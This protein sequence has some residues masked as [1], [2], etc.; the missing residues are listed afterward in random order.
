MPS[1]KTLSF[2]SRIFCAVM[3]VGAAW[4]QSAVVRDEVPSL[5]V[6]AV[7]APHVPSWIRYSGTIQMQP[8][9]SEIAL[10]FAIYKDRT[11]T[12]ALWQETQNVHPDAAGNYSVLLGSTDPNG[13]PQPVFNSTD[14]QW[15]GVRVTGQPESSRGLLVSVPYALKTLD[16]ETLQGVPASQFVQRSEIPALVQKLAAQQQIAVVPQVQPVLGGATPATAG[17]VSTPI[18]ASTPTEV[19]LVQQ[20]GAGYAL[21]AVATSNSAVLAVT[22]STTSSNPTIYSANFSPIGVGTRSEVLPSKGTG[23]G[24]WGA[25]F[26]DGGTGVLGDEASA[27]GSTYGVRGKNAS[28]AGTGVYGINLAATGATTGVRGETRSAT[29]TAGVFDALN[30]GKILSGRNTGLEK[31]SVDGLGN[32]ASAGAVSAG[33]FAG[34][35]SQLAN[36]NAGFLGGLPP[37]A[38]VT[39]NSLGSLSSLNASQFQINADPATASQFGYAGF[40]RDDQDSVHSVINQAGSQ[41]HFRLSRSSPDPGGA[42]DLLIV[43]Y[44]FGMAV[45]YPGVLEFWTG[46]FSVH[47]NNSLGGHAGA[48]FWVGD[49]PDS[50]GLFVTANAA[51]FA[52]P[53]NVIIA[54]DKFNHTSHGSL[55]FV[56]RNLTDGFRFNSGPN[57]Q[58]SMFGQLFKTLSTSNIE[59][60]NGALTA[61][62]LANSDQ[63]AVQVGSRSASRVDIITADSTPQISVFPSGNVSIG[64]TSDTAKLAVGSSAQFQVSA[65]GAVTIG[66]GT[67]IVQHISTT[68]GVS[69]TSLAAASCQVSSVIA[70][71]AAD[72][73]SVALGVPNSL[74]SSGDLVLFGWVSAPGTVS[75]RACNMG[76]AS[77]TN[78]AGSVRVDVWKH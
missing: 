2:V 21:H 10:T 72:G 14:A 23:I 6:S 60:Y 18:E 71:G 59:A 38:F 54:A 22:T 75:I 25:S 9:Q 13:L 35:G 52:D 47:E 8:G 65:A 69:L 77:V 74:A 73:D 28:V 36:V 68:A 41:V 7:D 57:G 64:N 51:S 34:D 40:V 62:L 33:S 12:N 55:N 49:Q 78:A 29:G 1:C 76:A 43:P 3:F 11:T 27:T 70:T 48:M 42:K 63:N 16:A 17:T 66:G 56:I 37:S 46:H 26:G 30:G 58:E 19:L 53:G 20:D 32:V 5:P 31:F 45:E 24:V 50:G 39:V 4:G 61:S 67:P 44:K 15:L